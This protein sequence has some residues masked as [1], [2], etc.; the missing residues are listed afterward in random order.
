MVCVVRVI[1]C[2]GCVLFIAAACC[3]QAPCIMQ[4]QADAGR[5]AGSLRTPRPRHSELSSILWLCACIY[6]SNR[7]G[8]RL[9][10]S[11]LIRQPHGR[12][13]TCSWTLNLIMFLS[14]QPALHACAWL[15]LKNMICIVLHSSI[16]LVF[17][18]LAFYLNDIDEL[19][20]K[21]IY[22]KGIKKFPKNK[23]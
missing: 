9:I 22:E 5:T 11:K 3:L 8:I 13:R 12:I 7:F 16:V 20:F 15:S 21:N 2:I 6:A 19:I 14:T 17:P 18:T 4:M 10:H 23:C 1:S